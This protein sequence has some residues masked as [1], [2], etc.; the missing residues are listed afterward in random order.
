MIDPEC[1]PQPVADAQLN[2]LGAKLIKA[3]MMGD[4]EKIEK[5]KC[6]LDKLCKLKESQDSQGSK[7]EEKKKVEVKGTVVLTTTDR[8]RRERQFEFPSRVSGPSSGSQKSSHSKKGRREKYFAD[9]DRYSLQDLVEQE[10][11]MT[12]EEMHAEIARVAS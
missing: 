1:S 8:F 11:K 10:R 12:A 7:A 5:L 9:D 2:T 3:E 4:T 6:E